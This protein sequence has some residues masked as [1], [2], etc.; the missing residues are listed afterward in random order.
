MEKIQ[1]TIVLLLSAILPL[2]A[3]RI[4]TVPNGDFEQ[5]TTRSIKE[6]GIV[7]GNTRTLYTVGPLKTTIWASSNAWARVMGVVQ[8]SVT[9]EPE[10]GPTGKCARLSTRFATCSVAGLIDIKVLATGALYWG[11]MLE[12]VTGVS[13]PYSYIDWG[14][15]FTKRPSALL[16]DYK[17][18]LP[19]T[20]IL[21]KGT[22]F[23]Q[24]EF[25]GEDPCQI[26]LILQYRW[27][28]SKGN[29]H[30]KRVATGVRRIFRSTDWQKD[31][32][33]QMIYGN[34]RESG[35]LAAGMNLLTGD[36]S[37]YAVN[38]R[39]KVKPIIEEGWADKN[40]PCTHAVLQITAGSQGAFVG[41]LGNTLWVDNIRLE[42]PE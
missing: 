6:S 18:Y 20:G 27:E 32:R 35:A 13:K 31:F 17:A 24:E 42:Y 26:L 38:S 8:A 19:N 16:L 15:P 25:P 4:E 22:T 2:H 5:W 9:M 41:A 7:G 14:I 11:K 36:R 21:T 33:V 39:G 40:T 12:P 23:K 1:I 28:D 3:Q 37:L 30:A 34:P 29:I 10:N